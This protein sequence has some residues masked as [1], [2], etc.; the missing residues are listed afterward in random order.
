LSQSL[1]FK[2]G[3]KE[4]EQTSYDNRTP[5]GGQ[6]KV[7]AAAEL[8]KMSEDD[9]AEKGAAENET[10]L[11]QKQKCVI[12]DRLRTPKRDRN[13]EHATPKCESASGRERRP[14]RNQRD[15]RAA[16]GRLD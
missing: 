8:G 9:D 15:Y 1:H 7:G 5:F 13:E 4:R 16:A 14:T 12:E 2:A 3:A 6:Q 11:A 10:E